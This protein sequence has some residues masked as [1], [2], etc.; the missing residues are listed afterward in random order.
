MVAFSVPKLPSN[1]VDLSFDKVD[2][3]YL[4][5]IDFSSELNGFGFSPSHNGMDIGLVNTDNQIFDP[6]SFKPELLLDKN[7]TNDSITLV[8]MGTEVYFFG[9][10]F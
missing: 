5:H 7:L 9:V 8:K 4:Y 3:I 1:R 10:F 2:T 6:L